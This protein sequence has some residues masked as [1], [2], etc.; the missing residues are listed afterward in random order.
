MRLALVCLAAATLCSGQDGRA[1]FQRACGTC[2]AA[3]AV[4]SP[5]SRQQWQ[6]TIAKMVDTGAKITDD[7]RRV[8]LDYLAT[9]HGP[10][11]AP[12]GGRGGRAAVVNRPNAGALDRHA[13]DP[14]AAERGRR[15]WAAECITC[16]GT[17]ARGTDNG[18][19]LIQS[20]LILRDR[21]GSELGPFLRKG[22]PLQ[23]GGSSAAILQA[24]VAELS[25]FIHERLYDTL[26]GSP[27]FQPGNV[28]TGDARDGAAFFNGAGKCGTCHSPTGDLARI[29]SRYDPITLQG[30]FLF[31]RAGGRGGRGGGKQMT[32]T[33]TPPD[34][35]AVTGVPIVF[36]DF[37]ISLRDAAGDFH[38]FA[39]TPSLKVVR[40]DPFAVHDELLD[41]Y[42]DKNMH[43][44]LA[45]LVT[46]K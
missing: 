4:V 11:A 20:V 8:I 41:L 14:A 10:S 3:D 25:H 35:P 36:S 45:Y 1:V 17:Y 13:V 30:R 42:T 15:V 16:H 43:D 27:I 12:I 44:V 9:H 29:G 46:L 39:R 7:E 33:V 24:Q 40:N 21:Y 2:H 38:S 31:P 22:H 26:R 28:V 32:I 23:S 6:D 37:H 18:A 19:N 5:R 34:R